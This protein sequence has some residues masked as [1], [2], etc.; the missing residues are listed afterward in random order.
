MID[1]QVRNWVRK[2]QRVKITFHQ[3]GNTY[4]FALSA[5]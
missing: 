3:F 2:A 4:K 5:F 1:E